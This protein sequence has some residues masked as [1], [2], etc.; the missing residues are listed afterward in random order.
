M[1]DAEK[2][3]LDTDR[4]KLSLKTMYFNRFLLIRYLSAGFF[5]TNLYWLILLYLSQSRLL[6]LPL[7][8]IIVI[9]T[10]VFEQA[11]LYSAPTNIVPRTTNYYRLQLIVNIGLLL[12]TFTP[13][14]SSL[15]PFMNQGMSGRTFITIFL[16]TGCLLSLW[17]QNRLRNISHNNDKHYQRIKQYEKSL[18]L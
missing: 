9:L 16:L 11:K 3:A 4:K 5:F 17:I 2:K 7:F 12:A 8:L 6:F 15:F 18:Y 13:L 1:K 14:F 10:S